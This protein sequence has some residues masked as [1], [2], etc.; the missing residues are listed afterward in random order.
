MLRKVNLLI[1]K[2]LS[3]FL[4]EKVTAYFCRWR[5]FIYSHILANWFAT[6][7]NDVSIGFPA[8]IRGGKYIIL[9]NGFSFKSGLRM[10]AIDQYLNQTFS[11]QIIIGKNVSINNDCHIA[12]IN[13]ITIKDNVV[14]ASKVFI[15]DHFHGKSDLESLNIK[16]I[17]RDL[18]SKGEI[19]IEENVWIGEGV[20]ILSNVIIGKNSIIGSNAVVTKDV[21]PNTV[22]VGIPAKSL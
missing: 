13:K 20:A 1:A 14:I 19:I 3:F 6:K 16:V 11:P 5:N 17:E 7:V 8:R 15:S 2:F 4:T 9:G 21:P 10:E 22:A 18:F 12:A